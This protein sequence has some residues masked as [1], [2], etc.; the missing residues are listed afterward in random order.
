MKFTCCKLYI[1][2]NERQVFSSRQWC[3]LKGVITVQKSTTILSLYESFACYTK[4]SYIFVWEKV[5]HKIC[6]DS[7]VGYII[8][9]LTLHRQLCLQW[10]QP[11]IPGWLPLKQWQLG[12]QTQGDLTRMTGWLPLAPSWRERMAREYDDFGWH[13]NIH[14]S[15]V[16]PNTHKCNPLPHI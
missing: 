1:A 15:V 10:Q 9:R 4:K 14:G 11:L 5:M 8:I 6:T 3:W 13:L 16:M 2:N 7:C 12:R